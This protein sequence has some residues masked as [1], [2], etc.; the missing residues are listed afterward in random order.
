MLHVLTAEWKDVL[1]GYDHKS[2]YSLVLFLKLRFFF[3]NHHILCLQV[4]KTINLHKLYYKIKIQLM[5]SVQY[6]FNAHSSLTCLPRRP[7]DRKIQWGWCQVWR[8]H[9]SKAE[10]RL[11][12]EGR[13]WVTWSELPTRTTYFSSLQPSAGLHSALE[14]RRP[15]PVLRLELEVDVLSPWAILSGQLLKQS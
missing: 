2:I 15:T 13:T 11:D 12:G 3:Y 6:F 7:S 9:R 5:V 4:Y 14:G 10:G 1:W 8:V